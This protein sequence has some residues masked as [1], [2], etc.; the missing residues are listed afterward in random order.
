LSIK[1]NLYKKHNIILIVIL[2]FAVLYIINFPEI[3]GQIHNI[4]ITHGVASGD[5]T[6]SSAIIWSRSNENAIMNVEYSNNKNMQN[7]VLVTQPVNE[8]SDFTGHVKIDNLHPDTMYF[9]RVWFSNDNKPSNNT[10]IHSNY[11]NGTFKTAPSASSFKP[12]ISFVIGGDLG[13][14]NFCRKTDAQYSIFSVMKSLAPDFFIFNGD[15]IYGDS[16]CSENGPADAAG[17]KNIKEFVP[18]VNQ[19]SSNWS[20]YNKDYEVYQKHWQYNRGDPHLQELLQ[21]TSMYSQLDDHEVINDFGA[22]WD[23]FIDYPMKKGYPTLV[24]AGY[25][26]FFN[27]SPMKMNNITNSSSITD[28]NSSNESNHIYRHFNWGKDLDLFLLDDHS[29]RSLNNLPDDKINKKTLLGKEQLRWLENG[30]LNSNATWKI[31][32]TTIPVT[33]PNCY[34]STRGCDNW[35]TDGTT[36]KTFTSERSEFLKFL[37]EKKFKNIVFITTDVHFPANIMVNQDFNGDKDKLKFYELVSGPLS[38]IPLGVG[39][40]QDP[41]INERFLYNE[42]KIFNFGHLTIRHDPLSNNVTRNTE[43]RDNNGL[44]RPNSNLTLI[45]G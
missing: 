15:Q 4:N 21:N 24:K 35:A 36:N 31:I 6:N 14:Q 27:Y 13:G 28:N 38:A 26:A 39:T 1:N 30:L 34:N 18:S 2:S 42:S 10:P 22:K 19:K 32:A 7:P 40:K 11:I 20:D 12:S 16:Y 29:Y 37:E 5:A 25:N 41:T 45:P 3:Y 8:S 33:I 44:V 17:W 23:H 9:Y 43:I